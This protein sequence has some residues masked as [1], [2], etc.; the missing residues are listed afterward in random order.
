MLRTL[1]D[2]KLPVVLRCGHQNHYAVGWH[3]S[4]ALVYDVAKS[5]APSS[6]VAAR[7][8]GVERHS[9]GQPRLIV[10]SFI[11]RSLVK[12]KTPETLISMQ[13]QRLAK[14]STTGSPECDNGR[15]DQCS[16]PNFSL[17]RK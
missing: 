15:R 8:D 4:L 7:F 6:S 5:A 16:V 14:R 13:D 2:Q 11:A 1:E 3:T 9:F 10:P 17:E 12:G